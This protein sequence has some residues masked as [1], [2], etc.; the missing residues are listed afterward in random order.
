MMMTMVMVMTIE[1][2]EGGGATR[3]VMMV[4]TMMMVMMCKPD[5]SSSEKCLFSAL[6]PCFRVPCDRVGCMV[7]LSQCW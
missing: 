3:V 2:S 6:A 1:M 7:G 5:L 4:M